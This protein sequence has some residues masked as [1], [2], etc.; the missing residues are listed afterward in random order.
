MT[1]NLDGLGIIFHSGS[2][3]RINHG[4]VLALTAQAFDKEV[5]LFFTHWSIQY[6][7]KENPKTLELDEEGKSNKELINQHLEKGHFKSVNENIKR[8]KDGGGKIYV[9]SNSLA[10]LNLKPKEISNLV[11]K[12]G[13]TATFLLETEGYQVLFI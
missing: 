9:C 8:V 10:L 2:F 4:L 13:G 1:E 3:D 7:K 5:V 11:G 12:I 6:L